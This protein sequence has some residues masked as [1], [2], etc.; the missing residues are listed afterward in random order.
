MTRSA[1]ERHRQEILDYIGNPAND[2]PTRAVLAAHVCGFASMKSLYRFFTPGELHELE[3]EGLAIRRLKYAPQLSAIDKG[4]I[5]AAS[6][7]DAQAAKLCYQRFEN[8][9]VPNKMELTGR[10]GSPLAPS[11]INVQFVTPDPDE[12]K[13]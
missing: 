4:I 12:S 9:A 1:R 7:G 11:T 6:E 13:T 8:W 2:F 3:A 5:Q 10:D